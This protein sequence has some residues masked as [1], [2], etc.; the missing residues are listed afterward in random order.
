[1]ITVPNSSTGGST[2]PIASLVLPVWLRGRPSYGTDAVLT[3]HLR[4]VQSKTSD[5][6]TG[7]LIWLGVLNQFRMCGVR[8]APTSRASSPAYRSQKGGGKI[9]DSLL[10]PGFLV[11]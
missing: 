4:P 2:C 5:V 7:C 9:N 11:Q 8:N 1:M 10:V 3:N 6:K